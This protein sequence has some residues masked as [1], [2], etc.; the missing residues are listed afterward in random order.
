MLLLPVVGRPQ[1]RQLT[2]ASQAWPLRQVA[3]QEA[4]VLVHHFWQR[5]M[6]EGV[7]VVEAIGRGAA[8]PLMVVAGHRH[9]AQCLGAQLDPCLQLGKTA[10]WSPVAGVPV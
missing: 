9:T 2:T 1:Q 10:W 7:M 5:C 3:V 8:A 4:A 6:E